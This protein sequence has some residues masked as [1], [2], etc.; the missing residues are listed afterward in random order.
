MMKANKDVSLA[1]MAGARGQLKLTNAES[2][3]TY[4]ALISG[5][6]TTDTGILLD[7]SQFVGGDNTEAA[8]FVS[9]EFSSTGLFDPTWSMDNVITIPVGKSIII[10]FG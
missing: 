5:G 3:Y 1:A 4:N 7:A 10:Y 8:D 2:P 6:L 9:R